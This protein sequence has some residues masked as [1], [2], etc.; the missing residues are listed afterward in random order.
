[1]PVVGIGNGFGKDK[2]GMP[3]WDSCSAAISATCHPQHE[4]V[5]ASLLPLVW[6]VHSE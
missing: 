5:N 2:G 6:G 1:M 3:L 4:D